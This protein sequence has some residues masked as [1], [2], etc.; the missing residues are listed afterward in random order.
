MQNN[1]SARVGRIRALP[2]NFKVVGARRL[3]RFIDQKAADRSFHT[4]HSDAEA[5]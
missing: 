2:P 5:A 4:Y 1:A 3:R